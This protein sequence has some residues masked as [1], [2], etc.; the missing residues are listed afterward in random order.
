MR[1]APFALEQPEEIEEV[2]RLLDTH[3]DDATLLAG[4]QTL[5]PLLN[6]RIARPDV[7]IDLDRVSGL[8]SFALD[9]GEVAIGAMTRQADLETSPVLEQACPLVRHLA[10]FIGQPQTRSRGTVG[11]SI[12]LGSTVAELCV[13]LLALG[14]RVRVRRSTGERWIES[15]DLFA[16]YLTTSLDPGEVVIEIRF[17]IIPKGVWWG[18]SELK[19]RA[20]D[21][22]IVVAA[23]VV[24]MEG[25]TC[26]EA[27]I[28]VGGLDATPVRVETAEAELV[29]AE[30]NEDVLRRAAARTAEVARPMGDLHAPPW[31]RARVAG[32]QVLAALRMTEA[33]A[34]AR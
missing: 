10:R 18:F 20:C 27:R 17:P 5:I 30:L 26:V 14:G 12:A 24:T 4:G 19:L 29:G 3:G 21:F 11:G 32:G 8:Q 22:P 28:A 1:P 34:S 13:A 9:D 2:L 16:G 7:L 33:G 25:G 15:E 23:A 6:M 31:Y